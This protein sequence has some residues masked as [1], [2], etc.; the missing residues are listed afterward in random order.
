MTAKLYQWHLRLGVIMGVALMVWAAS[1]LIHPLLSFTGIQPVAFAPPAESVRMEGVKA[2]AFLL[3]QTLSGLRLVMAE[4]QPHYQITLPQQAERVYYNAITGTLL[5]KADAARATWLARHYSG[6]KKAGI[7]SATLQ[8]TYDQNYPSINKYL[9]VWR[10]AFDRSDGLVVYVDTG[11][12]TLGSVNTP[13]KDTLLW[14][15]QQVHTLKFLEGRFEGL[16][17]GIITSAMLGIVAMAGLGMALL[18]KIRRPKSPKGGRGLHRRLAWVIWLPVIAFSGSGAF[19]LWVQTTNAISQ[20]PP[21]TPITLTH[22]TTLPLGLSQARD[23]RL[24]IT[25]RGILWRA[26]MAMSETPKPPHREHIH[27]AARA[28][29]TIITYFRVDDGMPVPVHDADMALTIAGHPTG[30]VPTLVPMFNPEY[31]FAN[32]RLPVWRVDT[33]NGLVFV[34]VKAGVVAARVSALDKTELWSFR[35]LHKGQFLD[36]WL[37]ITHTQRDALLAGVAILMIL[38]SG[39]GLWLHHRKRL[40]LLGKRRQKP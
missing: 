5:P 28:P 16:R 15:F 14:L 7:L 13:Y 1:G 38:M 29:K 9:P 36:A 37:G 35:N 19:H 11:E 3:V 22:I 26:Q 31:G 21:V 32:K 18:L 39:I 34:D 33:G 12:D 6:E 17:L 10:V 2:P 20:A 27:H 24:S 40:A 23:V 30:P 4:G 25:S 8:T